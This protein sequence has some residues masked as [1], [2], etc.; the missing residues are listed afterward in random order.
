MTLMFKITLM[1]NRLN[2]IIPCYSI[3]TLLILSASANLAFATPKTGKAFDQGREIM[4]K[5]EASASGFKDMSS[6]VRMTLWEGNESKKVT[7]MVVKV[8]ALQD[9]EGRSLTRFTKPKREK[10]ISL[11]TF[12]HSRDEDEQWIYLPSTKRIKKIAS[13]SKSASFRGSDFSFEDLAAQDSS[14]FDFQLLKKESCGAENCYVLERTPIVN[15]SSY[16]KAQLW[17]D[18]EHYRLHKALFYSKEDTPVKQLTTSNY[19]LHDNKY[20]KPDFILMK[21]LNNDRST[22]LE[23]LE[24]EFNTQLQENEFSELNLKRGR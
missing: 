13:S 24:V 20:W 3:I 10:G 11:L 23:V 22:T 17:I 2:R 7:E 15:S 12:T 19:Q 14:K 1:L 5:S 8:I 4:K 6:S 21:Q 16:S 18:M 9:G